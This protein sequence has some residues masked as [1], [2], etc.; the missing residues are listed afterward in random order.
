MSANPLVRA[1]QILL[2]DEGLTIYT[3]ALKKGQ[4]TVANA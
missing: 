3:S 4:F 2:A 1:N